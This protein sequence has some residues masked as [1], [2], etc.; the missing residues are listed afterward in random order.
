MVRAGL[1]LSTGEVQGQRGGYRNSTRTRT[2]VV[3]FLPDDQGPR[4]TE[5]LAY[6][7]APST[8][9]TVESFLLPTA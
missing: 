7:V 5:L 6:M 4:I 1:G 3:S 8:G 2:G 9:R